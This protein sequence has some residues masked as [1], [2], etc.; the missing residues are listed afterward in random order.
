[1][2]RSLETRRGSYVD[3]VAL[4]Q[5]STRVNALEGVRSALVAMAT[6]LNLELAAGMGFDVPSGL[7]PNEMLVALE[8]ED[9]DGL[10]RALAEV[11][12]LL[13]AAAHPA[14]SGFGSAP[15]PTTMGAAARGVEQPAVALVSTPG[16]YAFADAADAVDAG[17][18]TM[19][20][21]DNM[22]VEQEVALKERAEAAGVLLMGPDCGTAVIG[23][24]GLGFANV[25]RPGPV[26]IVAASGTGAQHLMS[27]LDGVDVGISHCLGVGGRDLS[28]AVG[29]RSTI[30]ALDLLAADD[31]TSHIVVISKPPAP[32]VAER[33]RAHG[34]SLGKPVQFALLGPGQPTLTEAAASVAA[35]AGVPWA[36]P[37]HWPGAL[38]QARPGFLRGLF[39]G[40][41]LC[42]E[43]MLVASA[44]LGRVSSNI[45]LEPDWALGDDLAS[46]GHTMVDFG[47]DRLTQ[48]RPHPMIDGSLR[49]DRL[50]Q[51]VA[52]ESCGVLLVDVVLGLGAATDPATELIPAL[53][54]A[55]EAGVPVVCSV[56]GTR[57]DP[58][59]VRRQVAVLSDAGA[60]VFL[61]NAHAA[62]QALDLLEV[63]S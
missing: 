49:V 21:S 20:F 43:A 14:P 57:D 17:L 4:M 1:M 36:A 15:A 10:T 16:E 8:A 18:H 3:S 24:V 39:S 37:E 60:W 13:S 38:T 34:A 44:R 46:V 55:R 32:A 30:R 22:P 6:D 25:V 28:E 11:D 5:V 2:K 48:G 53:E 61:S 27:L 62:A 45:P 31:A 54:A 19:V 51:E 29:G 63:A 26:G 59:G 9:D 58:Q 33:V 23:G 7:T 50:L 47:D 35:A 52:D 41:T 42:D 56:V 40:G 12:A